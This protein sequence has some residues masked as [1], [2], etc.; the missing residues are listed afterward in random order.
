MLTAAGSYIITYA[1]GSCDYGTYNL[2]L[3]TNDFTYSWKDSSMGTSFENGKAIL[4]WKDGAY[5]LSINTGFTYKN[6]S[7]TS[8]TSLWF[9][10]K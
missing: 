2:N 3:S 6:K 8:E 10:E 7:Y 9:V 5:V 1:D 4:T